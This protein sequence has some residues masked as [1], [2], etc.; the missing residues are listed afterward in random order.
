MEE[1]SYVIRGIEEACAMIDKIPEDIVRVGM[2]RSLTAGS[3]PIMKAVDVRTPVRAEL[4]N[5][6]T[7][8]PI[9]DKASGKL[10]RALRT[11]IYLTDDGRG[12]VASINFG[13]QGY[14]ANWVEY[15]HRMIG[16]KVLGALRKI[17]DSVPP[18]PFMR[19]AASASGEQAID[20]FVE[21]MQISLLAGTTWADTLDI[22]A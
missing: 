22:A 20:D 4:F 16:H 7:F 5:E 12:G 19:P 13:P 10:K 3:V 11:D 18:H 21:E 2:I 15:G 14:V 8:S 1:F 6:E 9:G 17:M